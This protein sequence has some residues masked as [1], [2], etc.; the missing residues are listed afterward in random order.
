MKH[1]NISN[2][3]D[4]GLKKIKVTMVSPDGDESYVSSISMIEEYEEIKSFIHQR[5]KELLKEVLKMLDNSSEVA[6]AII[7]QDYKTFQTVMKEIRKF[8]KELSN[9]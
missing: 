4:K 8:K 9:E 6:R 7:N 1:T 5:E 3:I 2:Q